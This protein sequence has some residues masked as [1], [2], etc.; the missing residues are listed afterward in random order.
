MNPSA[1]TF[2]D[3]PKPD[4]RERI[5]HERDPLADAL[6]YL[7]A[8][9]GRAISRE[10]L[11]AGLPIIDG[12]LSCVT[13]R[14]RRTACRARNPARQACTCGHSRAGPAGSAGDERR[15]PAYLQEARRHHADRADRRSDPTASRQEHAACRVRRRT[16]RATSSSSNLSPPPI[17][18]PS[19]P[20]ICRERTGSGRSSSRSGSNYSHVAI[21]ALIVNMLALAAPLFIMNVYDR[22]VP[23]RRDPIARSRSSIGLVLAI[24]FDFVLRIVRSRIIDHDRQEDRRR[25]RSRYLRARPVA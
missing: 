12:R 10:A 3:V 23:E 6:I 18:A 16:I 5:E 8:H 13:C 9:H 2:R 20:A 19:P 17:R 15:R 1:A 7:A 11:I 22:V 24:V 21:A 4:A 14:A 25:A